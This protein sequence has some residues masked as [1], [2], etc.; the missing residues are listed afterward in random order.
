MKMIII[1]VVMIMATMTTMMLLMMIMM[2]T[3][4]M[5][6]M[7]MMITTKKSKAEYEG[8]T[9]RYREAWREDP[10][11]QLPCS[12]PDYINT[13]DNN[14]NDNTPHLTSIMIILPLL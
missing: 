7:I 9:G 2:I 14:D 13:N 6:M 1:I 3:L 8:E 10:K 11:Q 12:P 5:L 4:M